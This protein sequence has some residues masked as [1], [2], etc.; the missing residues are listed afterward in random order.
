MIEDYIDEDNPT[1]LFDSFV[2]SLNLKEM[3][4][5]YAVLEEGPGRPSYNPSDL[6]KLYLWG[7]YN[8]IRS[9]RKL[10]NECYRNV[11]V[12]WLIRKFTP[13]FKT[14]ADFRKD[15][16][17]IVKSLFHEFNLFLR[18]N[19]L[20]KSHD[21]AVDG[22]KIKALNSMDRSYTREYLKKERDR[23]DER[24]EKYFRE[25]DENDAMEEDVD[26]E[27]IKKAIET[28]KESNPERG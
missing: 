13:D 21:V 1:R 15:N 20:F 14:I 4:F 24:I 27:K 8:G 9:S 17:D 6:L 26:K 11:E 25:M 2:D 7:Y 28:L 5:K 12:M 16:I 22:T 23:V 18:D 3:C 10:E 19:G